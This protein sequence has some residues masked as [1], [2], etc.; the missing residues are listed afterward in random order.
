MSYVSSKGTWRRPEHTF[1]SMMMKM[2][3]HYVHHGDVFLQLAE[4]CC[5]RMLSNKH[6]NSNPSLPPMNKALMLHM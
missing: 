2:W 5:A 4:D 6:V 3:Q 1:I